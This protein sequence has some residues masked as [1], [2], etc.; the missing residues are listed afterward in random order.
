MHKSAVCINKYVRTC[1][2]KEFGTQSVHAPPDH[3]RIPQLQ[4][5]IEDQTKKWDE[6]VTAIRAVNASIESALVNVLKTDADSERSRSCSHLRKNAFI[7]VH[8]HSNR[9]IYARTRA[10]LF[11][12]GRGTFFAI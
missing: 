4:K 3:A 2:C 9:C 12:R 1:G 6:R 10:Y 11:S 7:H 8:I 5:D